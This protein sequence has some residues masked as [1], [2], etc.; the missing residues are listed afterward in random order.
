[1]SYCLH[2]SLLIWVLVRFP[3]NGVRTSR[4]SERSTTA[5]AASNRWLC[6]R[7]PVRSIARWGGSFTWSP[8]PRVDGRIPKDARVSGMRPW[9]VVPP[10]GQKTSQN[11]PSA[12]QRTCRFPATLVS[13][14][15][16]PS[17]RPPQLDV[18]LGHL[19]SPHFPVSV[20]VG[21]Q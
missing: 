6:N 8:F 17:N 10:F 12:N 21:I 20:G 11:D 3:L 16:R 18:R 13:L 14:M 5:A 1:M 7:A 9:I 19:Q 2:R 15:I 4:P